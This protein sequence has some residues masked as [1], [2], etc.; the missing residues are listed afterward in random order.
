VP[1]LGDGR[2]LLLGG[3]KAPAGEV[4]EVQLKGSG[5]DALLAMGDGRAVLR[6]SMR[7]YPVFGSDGRARDPTPAPWRSSALKIPCA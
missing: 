3:V 2:A 6:S 7:E 1:Q 5:P 4:W